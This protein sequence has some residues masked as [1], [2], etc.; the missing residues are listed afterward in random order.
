MPGLWNEMRIVENN[1]ATTPLQAV[2]S[3]TSGPVVAAESGK[4]SWQKENKVQ[5]KCGQKRARLCWMDSNPAKGHQARMRIYRFLTQGLLVLWW[6]TQTEGLKFCS[7]LL[8]LGQSSSFPKPHLFN[9]MRKMVAL[10]GNVYNRQ[11]WTIFT[12]RISNLIWSNLTLSLR[13]CWWW[14]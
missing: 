1:T 3:E 9:C 10:A 7:A 6:D 8:T 4:N 5:D 11:Y 14:Q 2:C 13:K 12:F